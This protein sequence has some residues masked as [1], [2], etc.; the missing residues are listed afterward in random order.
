MVHIY[1]S[2]SWYDT[3]LLLVTGVVC[4]QANQVSDYSV[5][6]KLVNLYA[7]LPITIKL[8]M[9]VKKSFAIQP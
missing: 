9:K 5:L 6:D 4:C 7:H 8:H 1:L 2:A 3:V